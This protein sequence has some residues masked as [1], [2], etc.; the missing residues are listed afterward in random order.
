MAWRP[1]RAQ[2]T[3]LCRLSGG[4]QTAGTKPGQPREA[5][6]TVSSEISKAQMSAMSAVGAATVNGLSYDD[7]LI[8]FTPIKSLVENAEAFVGKLAQAL[9]DYSA[10]FDLEKI[11][12]REEYMAKKDAWL[13]NQ[14]ASGVNEKQIQTGLTLNFGEGGYEP[15]VER[16][17][18]NNEMTIRQAKVEGGINNLTMLLNQVFGKNVSISKDQDGRLTLGALDIYYGNGQKLLSYLS[19]GTAGPI[20]EESSSLGDLRF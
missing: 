8:A 6:G 2:S 7:P 19:L 5:G 1:T 10:Q 17:N 14:I 15:K 11:P 20:G 16:V 4:S 12:S 13:A 3:R 18:N 9:M